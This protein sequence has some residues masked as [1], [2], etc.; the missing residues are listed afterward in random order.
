MADNFRGI[1]KNF[2]KVLLA[3]FLTSQ[4]CPAVYAIQDLKEIKGGATITLEDCIEYAFANSPVIKKAQNNVLSAKSKKGQAKATYFPSLSANTGYYIQ[5]NGKN[6]DRS[7]NYHG[8]TVGLSQKIFD[9]GKMNA[10]LNASKYNI[11]AAE[12]SLEYAY[13]Q[14]AYNVKISYYKCLNLWAKVLI[15]QRNT[16]IQQLQLN[17]TQALYEEGL[18]SRIDVVDAEVALNNAKFSLA[19]AYSDYYTEIMILK[20]SMYWSNCPDQYVLAPTET[21]N[22]LMD[23]KY[24]SD[25]SKSIDDCDFNTVL[26]QGIKKANVLGNKKEDFL[27]LPHDINWYLE[28]SRQNNPYVLAIK[29]IEN[30]ALENLKGVKRMYNPDIDLDLGYNLKNT[31]IAV[32]NGFNVGVKF[33][34]GSVNAMLLKTK[35]DEAKANFA[36]AQ[37]DTETYLIDNEWDVRDKVAWMK[38]FP[39]EINI[40]LD[41]IERSL[42]YL[43]LADGRYTVG[44]GN[45]IELQKAANEYYKA[46]LEYV[47]VITEY[48]QVLAML[49]KSIGIR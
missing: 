3:V 17:R 26:T 20:N 41:Q 12:L 15:N 30:A 48:N 14:T 31:N 21:F 8:V 2:I 44:T 11:K 13:I 10:T 19:E 46:Q 43:Q 1:F 5:Q 6:W 49:N 40:K 45:F 4:M 36:M 42:E 23:Y 33:G 27:V 25:L 32:S 22:I 35:T 37:N 34:F 47:D 29:L 38:K 24:E 16:A 9:F 7:N 18:K 39:N 28:Q